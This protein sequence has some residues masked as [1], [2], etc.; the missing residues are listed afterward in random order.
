MKYAII[1][2][3]EGF[4]VIEARPA[5]FLRSRADVREVAAARWADVTDIR[6]A[7]D[8]LRVYFHVQVAGAGKVEVHEDMVGWEPFLAAAQK[9]LPGFRKDWFELASSSPA[10]H[11]VFNRPGG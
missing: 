6:V 5:G 3:D 8:G 11:P 7:G 1:L 10:Q 9:E 2:N 4:A